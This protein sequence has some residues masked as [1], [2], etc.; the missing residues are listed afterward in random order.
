MALVVATTGTYATAAPRIQFGTGT[1]TAVTTGDI[2]VTPPT[3]AGAAVGGLLTSR[4]GIVAPYN[5]VP[6][7]GTFA[8]GTVTSGAVCDWLVWYA[9]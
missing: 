9:S 5:F 3:G 4:S 8:V 6:S 1:Y 2:V 7:T